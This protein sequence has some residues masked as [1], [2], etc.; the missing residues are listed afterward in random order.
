LSFVVVHFSWCDEFYLLTFD[1]M[2][3]YININKTKTIKYV[4]I[5][6]QCRQL[7]IVYPGIVNLRET[8]NELRVGV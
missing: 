1:W 8:I 7:V 4:D 3:K 5:K 2:D 6:Q